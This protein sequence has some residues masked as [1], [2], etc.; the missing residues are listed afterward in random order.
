MGLWCNLCR[1][2]MLLLPAAWKFAV[3]PFKFPG[4]PLPCAALAKALVRC[5][6]GAEATGEATG[7]ASPKTK[8]EV[9]V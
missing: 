5:Q 7:E 9:A 6:N 4:Y 1:S 3:L 2:V 8:A